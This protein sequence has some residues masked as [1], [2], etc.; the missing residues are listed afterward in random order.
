VGLIVNCRPPKKPRNIHY[1]PTDD[2]K[3][4]LQ[5]AKAASKAMSVLGVGTYQENSWE[6]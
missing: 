6:G 3:P 5:C 1:G 2:L 4:G